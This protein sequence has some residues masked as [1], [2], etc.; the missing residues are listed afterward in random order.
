[1]D[2]SEASEMPLEGKT[3][4]PQMIVGPKEAKKGRFHI[5]ATLKKM[6]HLHLEGKELELITNLADC[7]NL[8]N[9]Y[10]QD[11]RIFTLVNDPF[12]GLF[13]IM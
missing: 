3:C 1:M 13:N 7:E 11:N 4:S 5:E 12:K 9:V 2:P 8:I 6:T 10:L